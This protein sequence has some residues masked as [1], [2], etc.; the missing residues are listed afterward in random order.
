MDSPGDLKRCGQR[1]KRPKNSMQSCLALNRYA[2]EM[3]AIESGFDGSAAARK[4]IYY[5]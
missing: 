1:L 5:G 4:N 3:P 2:A